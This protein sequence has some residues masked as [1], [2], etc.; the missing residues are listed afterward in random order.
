MF[1]STEIN[2]KTKLKYLSPTRKDIQK[3]EEQKKNHTKNVFNTIS[4]HE[5]RQYWGKSLTEGTKTQSK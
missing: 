3:K 4:R 1:E 5:I 2:S